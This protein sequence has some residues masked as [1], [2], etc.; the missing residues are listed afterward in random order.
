MLG[1]KLGS[2]V[3]RQGS[4]SRPTAR[5]KVRPTPQMSNLLTSDKVSLEN[6]SD[7]EATSSSARSVSAAE[8]DD[9]VEW[10]RRWLFVTR[11]SVTSTVF[12]DI[13]IP[14]LSLYFSWNVQSTDTLTLASGFH[15]TIHPCHVALPVINGRGRYGRWHER[16]NERTSHGPPRFQRLTCRPDLSSV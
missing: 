3:R 15:E 13:L 4:T 11:A 10:V 14:T 5:L 12:S 9:S 6:E 8:A 1:C 2:P 7:S 16:I